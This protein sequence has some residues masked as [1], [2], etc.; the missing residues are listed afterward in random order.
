MAYSSKP[1]LMLPFGGKLISYLLLTL[2]SNLSNINVLSKEPGNQLLS[3]SN[4]STD[5]P[6]LGCPM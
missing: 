3:N 6:F 1:S 4:Q 2:S 5:N